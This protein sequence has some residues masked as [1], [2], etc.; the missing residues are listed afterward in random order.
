MPNPD[1]EKRAKELFSFIQQHSTDPLSVWDKE[2][3]EWIPCAFDE[4]PDEIK[5]MTKVVS[6]YVEVEILKARID[7]QVNGFCMYKSQRDER[8]EYHQQQLTALEGK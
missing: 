3:Q 5:N 7:E 8:L 6:K 4:A 2:K 1:V